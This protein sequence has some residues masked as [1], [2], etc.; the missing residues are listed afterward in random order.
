MFYNMY[1]EKSCSKRVLFAN[2]ACLRVVAK[3]K[4]PEASSSRQVFKQV[5]TCLRQ[6]SPGLVKLA[7]L[8]E[9]QSEKLFAFGLSIYLKFC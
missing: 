5:K 9:S 4:L 7:Q 8:A 3:L 6:V 1:A 2:Y